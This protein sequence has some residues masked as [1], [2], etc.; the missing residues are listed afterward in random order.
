VYPKQIRKCTYKIQGL[1][2]D[3]FELTAD[4]SYFDGIEQINTTS[5]TIDA[6]VYNYSL[7]ISDKLNKSIGH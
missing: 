5:S 4:V 2:S 7:K 3:D 6:K 1:S